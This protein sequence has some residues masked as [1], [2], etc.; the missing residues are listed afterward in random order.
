MKL[1]ILKSEPRV[2]DGVSESR[3]LADPHHHPRI[4][5]VWHIPQQK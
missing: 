4:Y 2:Y 1:K 3:Y 5:E